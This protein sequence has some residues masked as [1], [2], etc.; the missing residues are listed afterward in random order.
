VFGGTGRLLAAPLDRRNH[1]FFAGSTKR[2]AAAGIIILTYGE[3]RPTGTLSTY[4]TSA[5]TKHAA[6][7]IRDYRTILDRRTK[8][9]E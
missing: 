6:P 2:S 1:R 8:Y 7:G 5:E 3:N 9:Y 4:Q